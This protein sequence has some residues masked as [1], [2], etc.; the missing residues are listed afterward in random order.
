MEKKKP[1]TFDN[2][3]VDIVAGPY[4]SIEKI[5]AV[6]ENAHGPIEV[7]R[8]TATTCQ[9]RFTTL[10]GFNSAHKTK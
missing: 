3:R 2:H 6:N 8:Q 10:A 7:L 1:I 5:L 9:F 4:A